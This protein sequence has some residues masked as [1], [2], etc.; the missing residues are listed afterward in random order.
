MTEP[1]V[2]S[3]ELQFFRYAF[4]PATFGES[5]GRAADTALGDF[6]K[7]SQTEQ[8]QAVDYV[9]S[10]LSK[11]ARTVYGRQYLAFVKAYGD[12]RFLKPLSRYLSYLEREKPTFQSEIRLVR[13]V[14]ETLSAK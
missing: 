6:P 14:I 4:S 3:K 8:M 13:E 9:L 1:T 2:P 12:A 7:L 5:M 11:N 10:I